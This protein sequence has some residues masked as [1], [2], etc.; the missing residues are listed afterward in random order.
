MQSDHPDTPPARRR[1]RAEPI[2]NPLLADTKHLDA[3]I[4]AAIVQL[5][6]FPAS[7]VLPTCSTP[8]NGKVP[9]MRGGCDRAVSGPGEVRELFR[10]AD[11]YGFGLSASG[12]AFYPAPDIVVFDLDEKNGKSGRADIAHLAQQL[13]PLPETATVTTP[14]GGEHRYFELPAGTALPHIVIGKVGRQTT[15]TDGKRQPTGLDIFA[16][17]ASKSLWV[18]GPGT[19]T[20]KGEYR[21]ANNEPVAMLPAAWIKAIQ[22]A[23]PPKPPR[24]P[25]APRVERE[26]V[27]LGYL[28]EVLA[29][30]DPATLGHDARFMV[31]AVIL[32]S[33]VL[34]EATHA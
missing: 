14:S 30:L 29:C 16:H 7:R 28:R 33:R 15:G 20:P 17:H 6:N 11:E 22:D 32:E 19:K 25:S 9:M 10:G 23:K 3:V 24:D 1:G 4:A 27:T 2:A 5:E 21:W 18:A 12:Y 26:T 13:G 31:R 34:D 8:S